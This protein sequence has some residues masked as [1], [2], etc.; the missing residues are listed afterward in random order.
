METYITENGK[1]ISSMQLSEMDI[2]WEQAKKALR[3]ES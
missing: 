2:Y 1:D 3:K